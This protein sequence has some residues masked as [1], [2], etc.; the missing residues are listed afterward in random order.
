MTMN[1]FVIYAAFPALIVSQVH[2]LHLRPSLLPRV[3]VPW[4]MF[5]MGAAVPSLQSS[6]G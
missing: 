3:M 6:T 5:L 4:P 1:T 2:G